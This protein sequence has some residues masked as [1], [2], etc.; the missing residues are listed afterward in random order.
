MIKERSRCN[1][2]Q[3]LV[4]FDKFSVLTDI[5]LKDTINVTVKKTFGTPSNENVKNTIKIAIQICYIFN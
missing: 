1:K 5:I 2:R 3:Y 4:S